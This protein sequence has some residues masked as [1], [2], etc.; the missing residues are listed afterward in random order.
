MKNGTR[1][2]I[3]ALILA[4]ACLAAFCACGNE[5][6]AGTTAATTA[7]PEP[8]TDEITTAE[9]VTEEIT[10][11]EITTAEV[12]T[13]EITTEEVTAADTRTEFTVEL[14]WHLGYVGSN[15][16]SSWADKINPGGNYY[17]FTEVFTVPSAGTTITFIDDNTNSNGDTNFASAAAYVISSW[18][19]DTSGN[20]VIDLEGTNLNGS[21]ADYTDENGARIYT[22]TTEKDNENLR[23]TFRSGEK[24]DFTPAAY[25]VVTAKGNAAP[26]ANVEPMF[27][28]F[29]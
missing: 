14:R 15:S 11:A 6:P 21:L 16:N 13:E 20:W 29:E 17:S 23:L 2:A 26:I 8:K 9:E 24:A 18:K 5:T 22:Y 4:L 7:A 27:G 19:Q 25:P 28:I 12:T 10:T 1:K 3:V